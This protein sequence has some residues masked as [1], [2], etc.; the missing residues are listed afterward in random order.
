MTTNTVTTTTTDIS[1]AKLI[2]CPA[3]VRRTGAGSGINALAASIQAHG[4]LQ[5]LVVRPKLD[6]E[7]QASGRYEVVAG[8]RMLAALKL[9][10]KQKR[11]T[12]GTAIPCRVMD[13]DGVDGAEASLAE[14]MVRQDMHPADQ[15]E[16]FHGLHQG[17]IG[18]ED[19]AA[20][21]G[22]SAYTVRQRLRLA[23]VSPALI[24]VYRDENLTLDDLT[25]FAVTENQEAQ[26]RV[27]GQLQTWQRNP[28][29]IRRLLTHAL[30][31]ATDRKALFV[32]M[33]AHTAAGGTMQRD[34]FS[35]DRGGWI[36]DAAL[37]ERLVAERMGREAETIRAEGCRWVSIGQEAQ[38]AAWNLRRVWPNKVALSAEDETP[39]SG[40]SARHDEIAEQHNRSGD[41]LPEEVAAELDRIEAE[42]AELEAREEAWQPEDVAIGGVILT[43]AVDG[44]L[45]IDRGYVRAE[46]E[47]KPEPIT[48]AEDD[49]A[50][51]GTEAED[52]TTEAESG[53]TVTP[54][55]PAPEQEDKAPALSATLLAELEVHRTAGLQAALA[56]QPELA[57]RVM[58]HALAT[59]A[60]YSRYGET[61]VALH[62][63]PPALAAACPGI[64]DSPARQ[65]LCEAED[66]WR[67]RLPREH[68]AFW[69][70]L[71][72]QDVP[73]LLSLMAVCVARATNA[74]PR[75]WIT[76]E[77]SQSIAA[78][79]ATAAGLDMRTCW[80]ASRDSY[81]GRV[82]KALIVEAVRE[83]AG[84]RAAGQITGSKKEVMV[85]DAEQLLAGTGWLPS[86]LRVAETRYPV[87]SADVDSLPIRQSQ[88]AAE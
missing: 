28:D 35:E 17:G 75:V 73:T 43:I 23:S 29:T 74:G 83:G 56:W 67:T 14:N 77:G 45:R 4:L 24:Q 25:A 26:E 47:P 7:G 57:L 53:S 51:D 39:R 72:D 82:S 22:V 49:A 63:Y 9:L 40:L 13:T 66:A 71:Q 62:T 5:S 54:F 59:D 81:L 61:V 31:P 38:A 64:A 19:I 70:W 42:L 87:D 58:V 68:G 84:M 12:K 80:T 18:I 76:S 10:A 46:D 11:I 65:T 86:I 1:L 60:L 55:R 52:G 37:L 15:F 50:Q 48:P 32:G 3:N 2:P 30:I 69:A 88:M 16:A 20:R 27:F 6:S 36:T 21:F 85:A 44:S 78:Q 41:D 34:L 33:D 8:G 79:V